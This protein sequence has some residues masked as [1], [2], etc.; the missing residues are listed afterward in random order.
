[1]VAGSVWKSGPSTDTSGAHRS[2]VVLLAELLPIRGQ[3]VLLLLLLGHGVQRNVR[4]RDRLLQAHVLQRHAEHDEDVAVDRGRCDL[5][6]R[7]HQISDAAIA[8]ESSSLHDDRAFHAIDLLAL[9]RVVGVSQL[10]QR[11]VLQSVESSTV[12]HDYRAHINQFC[13]PF[14]QCGKRGDVTQNF[15][16]CRNRYSAHIG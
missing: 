12:F 6:I 3:T 13:A 10:L 7:M 2:P 1:M 14:G 11:R 15:R 5:T 9:L 16:D 4:V 8:P